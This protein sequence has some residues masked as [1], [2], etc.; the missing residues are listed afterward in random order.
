VAHIDDLTNQY[1]V[2]AA[3]AS[4]PLRP[5]PQ[6]FDNCK[7]TP[8]VDV[9]A[10]N[11]AVE[12]ALALVGTGATPAAN[13]GHFILVQNW[14]LGLAGGTFT[15]VTQKSGGG[16][17][18]GPDINSPPY[19][20]DG[21]RRPGPGGPIGGT[22]QLINIIKDKASKGVDVR[23]MGWMLTGV[24]DDTI[25]KSAAAAKLGHINGMTLRSIS[26]LR[27]E[28]AINMKAIVNMISHPAGSAHTKVTVIGNTTK[29]IAFTGGVDFAPGRWSRPFH[30]LPGETWHD[31]V[32][33]VE[34]PG[35]AG[36]YEWFRSMWQEVISRRVISYR[37]NGVNVPS[38]KQGTAAGDSTPLPAFSVPAPT[39]AVG[40]HRVQV[41]RTVPTFNF[42]FFNSLPSP[43]PISFAPGGLFEFEN[44]IRKAISGARSYIYMEDQGFWSQPTMAFIHDAIVAHP[45]LRVILVMG[46]ADPNDPS[47]PGGYLGNA[48]NIGLL[49]GGNPT[50][51]ELTAAQKAQVGFFS[52][53][54]DVLAGPANIVTAVAQPGGAV[55]V[56]LDVTSSD[57]LAA[58]QL[59]RGAYVKA[60]LQTHL[61][62]ANPAIAAG[63][64]FVL[65]VE[66]GN[67]V[68]G[69]P[70]PGP[71]ELFFLGGITIHAKLTLVDDA[72][73]IA[74]SANAMRRSLYTDLE[75]SVAVVDPGDTL[76]KDLRCALWSDHFRHP[77]PTDFADIQQGLHAWNPAWGVAGSAPK[78]PP[79]IIP[80]P[81]PFLA[82]PLT[83]NQIKVYDAYF[84]CD[85]RQTWGGLVPATPD[86]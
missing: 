53:L 32:A 81:V 20:L 29:A 60:N 75:N 78:R 27:S 21:P 1:L 16:L 76:V 86:K 19:A 37:L 50:G 41:L 43:D 52:R 74:G 38:H 64:P 58:N 18:V 15:G 67:P 23:A 73:M 9:E 61:V 11:N 36:I 22:K 84:D 14:W 62:L 85:S 68:T 65:D 24:A 59:A 45:A 31:V 17:D 51:P 30:A 44:G 35:V 69:G 49:R 33:M 48:I 39:P 4:P 13:A 12:S 26:E 72:C 46:G 25:V 8:L 66:P 77:T 71:A 34:G 28:P 80:I 5:V 2:I 57:A 56:T 3:D 79:H 82:P 6:Q 83:S 63:A 10:F 42:A 55:R 70:N 40:A 7:V 47:F 54:N